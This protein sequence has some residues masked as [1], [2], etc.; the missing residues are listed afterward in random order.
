MQGSKYG[1]VVYIQPQVDWEN[2]SWGHTLKRDRYSF[3]SPLPR[4]LLYKL[5]TG[6]LAYAIGLLALSPSF[7][8]LKSQ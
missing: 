7:M 3:G 4:T 2:N 6:G 5:S 1:K 8:R